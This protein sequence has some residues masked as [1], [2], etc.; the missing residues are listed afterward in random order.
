[1][2]RSVLVAKEVGILLWHG[3]AWDEGRIDR[4]VDERDDGEEVEMLRAFLSE[5]GGEVHEAL[6]VSGKRD[7]KVDLDD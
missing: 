5:S 1:V 2:Q 6:K 7:S 4:V 3:F